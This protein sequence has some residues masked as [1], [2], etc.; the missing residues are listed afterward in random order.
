M[1]STAKQYQYLT[2]LGYTG[3]LA[4]KQ[5]AYYT[6][7]IANGGQPD[8]PTTGEFVPD[9][10][11]WDTN[12]SATASGMMLLS[13]FTA[14]RSE[15]ITTITTICG[16]TPA[17][18][19]PTLCKVGV[20]SEAS[21]G[22]LTLVAQSANTTSMWASSNTAYAVSTTATF[23]KVAGQRYA[24]AMICVTGG[25]LPTLV[26][27]GGFGIAAVGT[28]WFS[29]SPRLFASITGQTDLPASI[30]N[31]SLANTVPRR[32]GFKLS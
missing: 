21:S 2:N 27:K 17:A 20:Y 7:L 23:S 8:I 32:V 22:D 14:R 16:T 18:A 3:T 15:D 12:L 4:D 13:Y 28:Q 30:A 25:A 31:A 6:D 24:C 11:L 9:R 19:T 10:E 26:G 5:N 1:G 29:T